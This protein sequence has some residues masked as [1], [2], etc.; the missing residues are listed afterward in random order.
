MII[1]ITTEAHGA[2][3]EQEQVPFNFLSFNAADVALASSATY[4]FWSSNA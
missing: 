3:L 4:G 1:R 2:R